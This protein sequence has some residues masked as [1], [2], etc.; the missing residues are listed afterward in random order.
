MVK[1]WT[2]KTAFLS[3]NVGGVKDE[4]GNFYLDENHLHYFKFRLTWQ[5]QVLKPVTLSLI[6]KYTSSNH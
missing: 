3:T 1:S 5:F 4:D 2:P 6:Q